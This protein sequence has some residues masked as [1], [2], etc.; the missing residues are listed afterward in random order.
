MQI[1]E[2][3]ETIRDFSELP[4][5]RAGLL[6][7]LP[8]FLEWHFDAVAVVSGIV[9][10]RLSV[11]SATDPRFL[12]P[13]ADLPGRAE[14]E[15]AVAQRKNTIQ[16]ELEG[17]PADVRFM[18]GG[19]IR[20]RGHVIATL[21]LHR[22]G[23][24]SASSA[25]LLA[26]LTRLLSARLSDTS[27]NEEATVMAELMTGLMSASS[28]A[29]GA[30][31]ALDVLARY[32]K[33]DAGVILQARR[34]VMEPI[35]SYG[36]SPGAERAAEL[37]IGQS[38]PNGRAWEACLTGET[39][40]LPVD[41]GSGEPGDFTTIQPLGWRGAWRRA[42]V[43][44]MK[45]QLVFTPADQLMNESIATQL[46]L[47]F[48]RLQWEYVQ[49]QLLS[50]QMEVV[51][52]DA[53]G[54]YQKILDAAV[55][56]VPGAMTGSLLVRSSLSQPFRFRATSGYPLSGFRDTQLSEANMLRWYGR[57]LE[58]FRAGEPRSIRRTE[59]IARASRR[60]ARGEEPILG[61][62]EI[63]S[64]VCLPV[65]Y[66][67]DVLALIN[68]DN[69]LDDDAFAEDSA[70]V[71]RL[72][73]PV[74]GS[75]LA[76]AR[77]REQVISM[78]HSDPLT[79]LANRRGADLALASQLRIAEQHNEPFVL[80]ALDLTR[81]KDI[82]DRYGHDAGDQALMTVARALAAN[83][84]S[85]DTI[86]RWG[87]DE[88]SVLLPATNRETGEQIAKRLRTAIA[89]LGAGEVRLGV[90]IG[91]AAWPEDGDSATRLLQVADDR[92]YAEK[93]GGRSQR[94]DD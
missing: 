82:N 83:A 49:D 80:L 15:N 84:R 52:A 73:G 51:D 62:D 61:V 78:A 67:G 33:A 34:S 63:L 50:L 55:E 47:A 5:S 89:G 4:R 60:G 85:G 69:Q 81:F 54:M 29:A 64:T 94:R 1:A 24:F 28:V 79:G 6:L 68:L 88:F 38:Y 58:A 65:A 56:L 75:M 93:L 21:Q 53:S 42:L 76:A 37:G 71:L 26:I 86:A 35:A 36:F 2:L 10:G 18:V 31:H 25:D 44:R 14:L 74:V 72:F 19:V 23:P 59:E 22:G 92:M 8:E 46:H 39:L 57:G 91:L 16:C 43:L 77:Q 17:A 11:L 3:Q 27:S 41:D 20:E 70:R 90:D 66:R 32:S 48:D 12:E 9:N 30:S 87:G 40:S 13:G 7:G 45:K